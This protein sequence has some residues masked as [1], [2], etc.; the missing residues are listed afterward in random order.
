MQQSRLG[1]FALRDPTR[2]TINA[3]PSKY[4]EISSTFKAN[5]VAWLASAA[6]GVEKFFAASVP[7]QEICPMKS[8]G[9]QVCSSGDQL[10]A[11]LAPSA[12]AGAANTQHAAATGSAPTDEQGGPPIIAINGDNPA[13]ISLSATYADLGATI[14]GPTEDLNLGLTT[15]LA[16][17]TLDT[18][19][20]GQH[21]IQYRAFDQSGL[22]GSTSRIVNVIGPTNDNAAS[23][24][25]ETAN[26]NAPLSDLRPTGTDATTTAQ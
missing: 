1:G 24:S 20:P 2:P 3:V 9:T 8:D 22:M 21:T 19:A 5:L 11:I 7:T 4:A 10:V 23:S 14:T 25:P 13:N 16:G 6:N 15:L 17:A 26:D 18:S 12:T